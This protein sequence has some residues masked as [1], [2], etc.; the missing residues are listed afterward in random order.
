MKHNKKN[1]KSQQN[2]LGSTGSQSMPDEPA[3]LKEII[4]IDANA[5]MSSADDDIDYD[6]LHSFFNFQFTA[7]AQSTLTIVE[8]LS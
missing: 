4:Y 3:F 5:S 7:L 6:A 1:I 8:R 2:T